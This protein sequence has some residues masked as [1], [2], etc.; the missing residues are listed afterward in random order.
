MDMIFYVSM[1]VEDDGHGGYLCSLS[2]SGICR[3]VCTREELF[4]CDGRV[5]G[6]R[7]LVTMS[8]VLW[9]PAL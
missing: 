5:S 3:H 4:S 7:M 8:D 6:R 9:T 1:S 2:L